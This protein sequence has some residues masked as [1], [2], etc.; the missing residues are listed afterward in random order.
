MRADARPTALL[1]LHLYFRRLCGRAERRIGD[2]RRIG[3]SSGMRSEEKKLVA[4]IEISQEL[5][6]DRQ[7]KQDQA[8]KGKEA[9]GKRLEAAVTQRI[10]CAPPLR[11]QPPR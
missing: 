6:K 5:E 4:A 10:V 3:E 8:S 1:A 11:P 2:E 7:R 9:V